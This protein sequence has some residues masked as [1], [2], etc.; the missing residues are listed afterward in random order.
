MNWIHRWLCRSPQ[1]RNRLQERMPWA[2]DG[3]DLGPQVLEVGPGPGLTTD[4]L[5]SRIA[6]LT[7]LEIDSALANSLAARLLGSNVTVV[8]GDATSMP[9]ADAQFSA[10]V[11]FTMLHHLPSPR[12]QDKLLGEVLRVLAPGGVFVGVDSR[13]SLRMRLIHVCDT[14]V[15][16]DPNSFNARLEAAGFRDVLIESNKQAFRFRARR[17]TQP[18]THPVDHAWP[19]AP[20]R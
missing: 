9:F 17:A 11:S 7:V 10:A 6:R 19:G 15:P 2:L 5:R 18:S 8:C 13:Q 4:L 12:L 20:L 16:V 14:L 3:I 1:W